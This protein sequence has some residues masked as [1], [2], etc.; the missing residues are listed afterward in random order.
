[1]KKLSLLLIIALS[2]TLFAFKSKIASVWSVDKNHAK[3]GF[4]ITHLLV[5]DVDGHFGK[6]DAKI[7]SSKEDFS[8][9][10]LDMTAEAAS[11]NTDNEKRDEHLRSADFFDVA[12]FPSI[13]F[14]S[15]SFTPAG[16]GK[17]TVKGNLTMKGVT[18]PIVLDATIRQGISPMTK[19]PIAGFKISG[20]IK[21]SDFGIGSY[22]A[23]ILS[24]EV[25]ISGNGEFAKVQ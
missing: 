12:K 13:T 10:V 6:F 22:P 11:I 2:T 7:T 1:M 3:I 17:Y 20:T 24:N 4:T 23:A 5:S 8:D 18:K 19:G 14:K 21:R 16:A 9:A 25:Q 15:T